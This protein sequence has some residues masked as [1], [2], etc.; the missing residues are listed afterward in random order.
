MSFI[1]NPQKRKSLTVMKNNFLRFLLLSVLLSSLAVYAADKYIFKVPQEDLEDL[2]L[3][4]HKV[5]QVRYDEKIQAKNTELVF[6]LLFPGTRSPGTPSTP[7]NITPK[8]IKPN[9]VICRLNPATDNPDQWDCDD[10]AWLY[11]QNDPEPENCFAVFFLSTI[12]GFN[13]AFNLVRRQL[14][15]G[16]WEV[17]LIE[18]SYRNG[19]VIHC[20]T[21]DD[22]NTDIPDDAIYR[23]CEFYP[24]SCGW[25]THLWRRIKVVPGTDPWPTCYA[26]EAP[27]YQCND[28]EFV[29]GICDDLNRLGI[30]CK[31]MQK[32][33]GFW[34]NTHSTCQIGQTN[35]CV[36]SDGS[37]VALGCCAP[38]L[39]SL[40]PGTIPEEQKQNY[41]CALTTSE[42]TTDSNGGSGEPTDPR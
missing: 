42:S 39:P 10:W 4:D 38:Q 24:D 3:S 19:S 11:C 2:V 40:P 16:T 23:I 34:Y 7:R 22:G 36:Q 15:D 37:I 35:A 20:W 33:E 5:K 27:W 32:C 30:E 12:G 9:D 28:S 1:I 8:I 17:C 13:H 25:W 31:Q 14:P 41:W 26:G 6:S 29:R 18:P 21:N